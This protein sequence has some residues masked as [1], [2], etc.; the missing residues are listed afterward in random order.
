MKYLIL[1]LVLLTGCERTEYNHRFFAGDYACYGDKEVFVLMSMKYSDNLKV[2][3]PGL[4]EPY[5]IHD[6]NLKECE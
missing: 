2:V 1:V 4:T 5:Y 3:M 6:R